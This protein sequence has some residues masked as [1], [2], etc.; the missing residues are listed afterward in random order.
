MTRHTKNFHQA[1]RGQDGVLVELFGEEGSRHTL[2]AFRYASKQALALW[3]P[4]VNFTPRVN[5]SHIM[6]CGLPKGLFLCQY[7]SELEL[8]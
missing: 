3:K 4:F 5:K 7:K 2:E 8:I 1:G 6:G